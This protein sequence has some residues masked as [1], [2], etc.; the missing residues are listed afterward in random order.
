MAQQQLDSCAVT[1]HAARHYIPER[2]QEIEFL[3][4]SHQQGFARLAAQWDWV[5]QTIEE[6]NTPHKF[7]TLQS[8]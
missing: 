7:I 1:S 5:R 3:V 8:Y 6:A 2:A 4:E